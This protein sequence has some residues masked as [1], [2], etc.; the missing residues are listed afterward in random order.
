MNLGN[1]PLSNLSIIHM[2]KYYHL[3]IWTY[4]IIRQQLLVASSVIE[5]PQL[6]RSYYNLYGIIQNYSSILMQNILFGN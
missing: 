6:K 2:A 4:S 1:S 3:S 5:P